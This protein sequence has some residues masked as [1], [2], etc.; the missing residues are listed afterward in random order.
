[1]KSIWKYTLNIEDNPV[2]RMPANAQILSVGNQR[3]QLCLWALVDTQTTVTEGRHF[4]IAGTGHPV[5][6][7]DAS[8][9]IYIGTAIMMDGA[10][11][12][13]VFEWIEKE[14]NLEDWAMPTILN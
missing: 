8:D 4:R 6:D 10:L 11:V 7:G 5:S 12:W 2:L 14:N 13:H 3:E 9:Y 1:M